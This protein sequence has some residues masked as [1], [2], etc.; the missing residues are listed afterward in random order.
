MT[1]PDGIEPLGVG[2][3]RAV[4]TFRIGHDGG[5]YPVNTAT[6]WT[7]GWNVATCARGRAHTPPDPDCRCGFYVYF[8][9][10]YTLDQPP[11]RQ[12]LAVVE[13][14]GVMEIGTRGGRV[15]EARVV[16]LWL[17]PRV[18]DELAARVAASY[19][20]VDLF[21]ER[22]EMLR[23]LPL[24]PVDGARG[25]RLSAARRGLLRRALWAYA[26][27]AGGLGLI[28]AEVLTHSRAGIAALLAA[29]AIAFVL[30]VG[31][32][33]IRTPMVACVGSSATAWLI[34]D[35]LYSPF[36]IV[37]RALVP[38]MVG[39]VVFVWRRAARPG[40]VVRDERAAAAVRRWWF[41][42]VDG[43]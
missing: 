18:S 37:Y 31:G 20:D 16:G 8:H 27:V 14:R 13:V 10:E 4:R 38:V 40:A 7:P 30:F 36:G 15:P 32:L 12:V 11:A 2:A 39:W 25:P 43:L 5:L 42:L 33:L 35:D 24:T 9:P 3:V 23:R 34:T 1:I 22:E 21:R 29:L 6:A 41:R 28:P 17:G 26:V 19:R